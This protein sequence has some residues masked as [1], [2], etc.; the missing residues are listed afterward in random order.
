MRVPAN[1]SQAIKYCTCRN[2]YIHN[3]VWPAAQAKQEWVFL[4]L[5]SAALGIRPYIQRDIV[6]QTDAC[7]HPTPFPYSQQSYRF[8]LEELPILFVARA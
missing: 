7:K 4:S 2:A 6:D 1:G 3:H 8:A 5:Q